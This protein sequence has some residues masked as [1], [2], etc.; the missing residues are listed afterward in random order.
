MNKKKQTDLIMNPKFTVKE[1]FMNPEKTV[2]DKSDFGF[3][4]YKKYHEFTKTFDK[5]TNT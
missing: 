2:F 4:K 5:I 1:Q 3:R